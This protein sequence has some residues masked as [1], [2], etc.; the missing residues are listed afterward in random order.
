MKTIEQSV[1]DKIQ[2]RRKLGMAKYGVGME[3]DDLSV[4]QWLRH[5]QEEC[6]DQALYL[7]KLIQSEEAKLPTSEDIQAIY[8]QTKIPS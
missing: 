3:R 2:E 7:E 6:M 8:N 5:A 1:C 4:L